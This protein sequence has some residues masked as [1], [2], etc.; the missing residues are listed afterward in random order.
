LRFIWMMHEGRLAG[1]RQHYLAEWGRKTTAA[2][3]GTLL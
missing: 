3:L 2:V 1:K